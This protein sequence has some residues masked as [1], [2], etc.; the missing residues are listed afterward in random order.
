MTPRIRCPSCGHPTVEEVRPS[1]VTYK[2]RTKTVEIRADWCD[3][4]GDGVLEGDALGIRE[5][6]WLELR[7]EVDGA[8]GSC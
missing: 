7:T 5:K 8:K 3:A 4:C 1:V 2:G 6:A